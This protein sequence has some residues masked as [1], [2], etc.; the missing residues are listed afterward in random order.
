MAANTTTGAGLIQSLGIGSGLDIKSL[1]TQLVAA[2]RAP[3]DARI[4]RQSQ[5]VGTSL[6]AVGTLKGALA[7]FQSALAPL[8]TVAN[9]QVMTAASADET[10]FTASAAG[11]IAGS[12]GVEVRQLA[13]PEQLLSNP[14]AIG[15]TA[16]VGTGTLHITLG[17]AGFDAT[18]ATGAST[19]ADVRDAINGASGN[20]GVRATLVYGVGGAQLVLASAQTGAA[21][22]IRVSASGGD[23]GLAQLSYAGT[24]GGNYLETQQPQDAIAVISGVEHHSASNVL[25]KAIDGV[26]LNLKSAKLGTTV[27]LTVSDDPASVTGNVQKLVTAY[28]AMQTQFHT[29]G[30][31]NAETKRGGPLL[32]DWLL[33]GVEF[34]LTRGMTDQVKGLGVGVSS[35]AAVGIT[36]GADGSLSVDST[37]LQAALKADS[38]SVARLFSGSNGVARRLGATLDGLLSVSGAIAARNTTLATAAARHY[39][40][41][42]AGRRTDGAG[43]TALPYSVQRAR[44]ADVAAPVH[45]E[46][47][48]SA[49]QQ[50]S[51]DRQRH[52]Y[53]LRPVRLKSPGPWPLPVPATLEIPWLPTTASSPP[54]RVSPSTVALRPT[55]RITWC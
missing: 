20:I 29:L 47:S 40:A 22:T 27:N 6:S 50:H 11:A 15:A 24:P 39:A 21:N 4:A 17:S 52:Q 13:Q 42:G 30:D 33:N 10:I 37:K 48:H 38:A 34:Q 45:I 35:L 25:D 55:I 51:Q 46:L 12:Y 23:G 41:D 3:M 8:A 44:Y 31:Y 49:A 43:A 53:R 9:F 18:I 19:L 2:D 32:G 28:N 36:T 16:P 14:F 26:T 1:V 5:S 54:T 7:S